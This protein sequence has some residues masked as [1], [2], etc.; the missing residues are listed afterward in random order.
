MQE[1]NRVLTIIQVIPKTSDEF[2]TE[3]GQHFQKGEYGAWF[4]KSVVARLFSVGGYKND[5]AD[6][7]EVKPHTLAESVRD[8]LD[9]KH[10]YTVGVYY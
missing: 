9:P 5:N 8:A 6:Y 2:N 10:G 1:I 4:C 3:A 7:P